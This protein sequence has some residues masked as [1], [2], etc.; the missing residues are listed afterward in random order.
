MSDQ[1]PTLA[2]RAAKLLGQ[3]NSQIALAAG[4]IAIVL[5]VVVVLVLRMGGI[6][7]LISQ[8]TQ[9]PVQSPAAAK[10]EA[11][12]ILPSFDIVRVDRRGTAVIAGRALPG[13]DVTLK[14]GD[15]VL[16]KAKANGKG[17][18][19]ITIDQ[20]L[21]PGSLELYLE[22]KM[23]DGAPVRS[24][25]SVVVVVP[26]PNA[27][28]SDQPLVVLSQP[29]QAS[30][31]LQGPAGGLSSGDLSLNSVDYDSN[32]TVVLSGKAKPGT[33]IR[34]YLNNQ[35]LGSARADA[36]GRWSLKPSG[37]IKPGTYNLRLDEIGP[38]GTVLQRLE[39]PFE[40]ASQSALAAG[41]Q[42]GSVIVQPGNSLWRIARR[43]YGE[44]DQFTLI[45]QANQDAI[46]DPDLIYPGQI[47]A[48]PAR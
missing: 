18:W 32:G 2:A 11:S 15:T 42:S 36:D 25:Q 38:D 8:N 46:K 44:G 29:G 39:L 16:G 34:P 6:G 24:A 22:A 9:T 26:D 43:S 5:F 7:Q 45:Y 41:A 28:G 33:T 19:V 20:P 47:L 17:E 21:P 31:V 40:R 37:A 10:P 13:A 48:V 27:A 35:P 4:A 12:P 30:R 1:E 23:G 3:R 14:A